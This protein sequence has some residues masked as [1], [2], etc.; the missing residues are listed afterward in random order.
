MILGIVSIL[1]GTALI[2]PPLLSIVFGYKALSKCKKRPL[3]KGRRM[4]ISGL[5]MGYTSIAF[6]LSV[7]VFGNGMEN[8][9]KNLLIISILAVI[10]TSIPGAIMGLNEKIIIYNGRRDVALTVVII[11]LGIATLIS[12]QESFSTGVTLAVINGL[13]LC[14]SFR[15]SYAANKTL[16]MSLVALATKILMVSIL[17]FLALLAKGSFSSAIDK[18]DKGDKKGGVKDLAMGAGAVAGA[19]FMTV[20][21]KK[22]IKK[23]ITASNT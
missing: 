11:I 23:H 8:A 13:L 18:F 21:I 10:I 5:V 16:G 19:S 12:I 15:Y 17:V 7:M 4:A 22:L 1:G 9:P 6:M 20:V 3:L 14:L 2:I